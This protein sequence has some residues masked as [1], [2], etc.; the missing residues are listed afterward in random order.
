MEQNHEENMKSS[1]PLF[2]EDA[3]KHSTSNPISSSFESRIYSRYN[4]NQI[5]QKINL[6]PNIQLLKEKR[7]RKG[8]IQENNVD[9][10]NLTIKEIIENHQAGIPTEKE[11]QSI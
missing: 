6:E 4:Q 8:R 11:V 7:K 2:N 1:F 10:P 3:L 5:H 9:N